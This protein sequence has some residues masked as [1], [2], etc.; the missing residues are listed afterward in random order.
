MPIRRAQS[1]EALIR[2]AHEGA[3]GLRAAYDASL[4]ERYIREDL[5]VEIKNA[6]ENLRSCLDYLAHEVFE[7]WCSPHPKP[8]RLYFPIRQSESDFDAVIQRDFPNLNQVAPVIFEFLKSIQP[9]HDPWLREFNQLN[10]HNK[11]EDLVPQTR[12]E[13]RHVTVSSPQGGGVSWG[14]GVVFGSGVSVMG[15][16]IDPSTQ[17]PVPNNLVE[18]KVMIWVD[19]RFSDIDEPVIPFVEASIQKVQNIYHEL[20]KLL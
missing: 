11:H 3:K 1:I 9:F 16:P 19:F 10:N 6:F 20:S 13:A 2:K 4:H 18:T 12:T 5:K 17:L 14:P 7:N 15:V 8:D